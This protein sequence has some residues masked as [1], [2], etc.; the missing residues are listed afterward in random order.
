MFPGS[1]AFSRHQQGELQLLLVDNANYQI[2]EEQ[3]AFLSQH[4]SS[5]QPTVLLSHIPIS[6]PTLRPAVVANLDRP[7]V[8]ADP[9]WSE[10]GRAKVGNI[11]DTKATLEFVRIVQQSKHLAASICGHVHLPHADALNSRA[12]QYVGGPVFDGYSRVFEF[13]PL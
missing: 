5:E 7:L 6:L 2:D 8:L 1:R 11:P 9:D 4:M 10:E 13:Q 3:L 12:V